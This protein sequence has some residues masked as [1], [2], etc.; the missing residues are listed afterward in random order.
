LILFGVAVAIGFLTFAI[1]PR[2][3]PVTVEGAVQRITV[4][5][6]L[7][8][9]SVDINEAPTAQGGIQLAVALRSAGVQSPPVSL[10]RLVVAVSSSASG[11]CPPQ[12]IAC[13]SSNGARTL[14][15]RF[16]RQSWRQ[17]GTTAIEQYQFGVTLTVRNIPDVVANLAQDSQDIATALPPVS[18]LQYVYKA[19]ARAPAPTY[20]TMPPVVNYGERVVNGGSYTW[21]Q[22]MIPVDTGGWDHWWYPSAS[23]APEALS[24]TFYS[25]TDLAV[26]DWNTTLV[27][28]AG[29]LVGIAG[30]AL[31]GVVQAVAKRSG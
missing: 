21:Q 2:T 18:V 7:E 6:P 9:S 1:Y 14:Y 4:I 11:R 10:E 28:L 3:P 31:V 17:F 23:T 27:F 8:P 30:A 19:G 20:F 22:G 25:G 24:P 26:K 12:A 16:P 13:P 5:G 29:I 15:Y